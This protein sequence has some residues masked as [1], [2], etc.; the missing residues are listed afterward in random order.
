MK[1]YIIKNNPKKSKNNG[2][3]KLIRKRGEGVS[4]NQKEKRFAVVKESGVNYTFQTNEILTSTW[5]STTFTCQILLTGHAFTGIKWDKKCL[6]TP[7]VPETESYDR[8]LV[9]L[10]QI[11]PRAADH[12]LDTF[13]KIHRIAG[14]D[15][16]CSYCF[17]WSC[18]NITLSLTQKEGS[19]HS[20]AD[21][22]RVCVY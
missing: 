10:L 8:A 11:I 18:F 2:T 20:E 5:C 19:V 16:L 7:E 1:S 4:V 9:Q 12:S 17:C 22:C 3:V 21:D 6:F 14:V 13:P 15:C